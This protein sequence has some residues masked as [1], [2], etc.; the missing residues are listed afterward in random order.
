MSLTRPS[1]TDDG[2]LSANR[3][4]SILP[5]H[6]PS[7]EGELKR[8]VSDSMEGVP[9]LCHPPDLRKHTALYQHTIPHTSTGP[10]NG[11]HIVDEPRSHHHRH[12]HQQHVRP[13]QR[14]SDLDA[15]PAHDDECFMEAD[16]EVPAA[17]QP[18]QQVAAA[19]VESVKSAP[20]VAPA[21]V[22][23]PLSPRERSLDGSRVTGMQRLLERQNVVRVLSCSMEQLCPLSATLPANPLFLSLFHTSAMP[24]I[25]IREY[26]ERMAIYTAVSEESMITA[27]IH[28]MRLAHNGRAEAATRDH[29]RAT[30]APVPAPLSSHPRINSFSPEPFQVSCFNIH[31]LLLTALLVT[32]KYA[33]DAFHNNRVSFSN[34]LLW[35]E[36]RRAG[37]WSSRGTN[38]SPCGA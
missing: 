2:H 1:H 31:R 14:V 38:S 24:G 5:V 12:H 18:I 23:R 29:A 6:S 22:P 36:Q 10:I 9:T 13:S 21:P 8:G 32:A 20:A 3:S 33:D 7:G 17:V 34:T 19:P 11:R 37:S 35:W 25:S 28:I 16:I 15:H 26:M 4:A 27:S 30:G